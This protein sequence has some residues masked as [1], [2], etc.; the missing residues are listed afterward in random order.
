MTE[1]SDIRKLRR[2]RLQ[3]VLKG[4]IPEA[5][6][7]A[8]QDSQFDKRDQEIIADGEV[9]EEFLHLI[10]SV[11]EARGIAFAISPV[12]GNGEHDPRKK[13]DALLRLT[14]LHPSLKR[15]INAILD[16]DD[17]FFAELGLALNFQGR[18]DNKWR[19]IHHAH[20]LLSNELG[21]HP[22]CGEVVNKVQGAPFN[23]IVDKETVR[24]ICKR[25]GLSLKTGKPGRPS[26]SIS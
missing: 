9:K 11:K 16:E 26:K 12:E 1:S 17:N 5:V 7:T 24:F 4:R 6:V 20:A 3:R 15:I 10:R 19:D 14:A 21:R 13:A 23:R 25:D 2:Q 22:T 18:A 8:Q